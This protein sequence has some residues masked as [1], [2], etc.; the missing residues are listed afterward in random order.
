MNF[1]ACRTAFAQRFMFPNKRTALFLVAAEAGFVDVFHARR[2]PWPDLFAVRAVAVGAAH[3]AFQ[4][5]VVVREAKFSLFIEMAR[6][7]GAR[8]FSRIHYAAD[9]A[10]AACG[11]MQAARSV[12]HLATLRLDRVTGDV[13][14]CVSGV[15]KFFGLLGMT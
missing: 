11:H 15:R 9:A 8:I 10:S 7:T 6:E 5:G 4:K 3:L 12:A 13:D 14:S 1:V 2:R